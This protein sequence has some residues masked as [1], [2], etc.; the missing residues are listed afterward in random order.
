MH[1][2]IQSVPFLAP[3]PRIQATV[4]WPTAYN[5]APFAKILD[6]VFGMPSSQQRAESGS[7]QAL[8]QAIAGRP[9]VHYSTIGHIPNSPTEPPMEANAGIGNPI[10]IPFEPIPNAPPVQSIGQ[11]GTFQGSQVI[12]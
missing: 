9:A 6:G 4:E 2:H 3:A 7:F 10:P 1:G 12:L 5:G 8:D 11:V